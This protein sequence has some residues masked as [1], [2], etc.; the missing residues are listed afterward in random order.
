M[1][2]IYTVEYYSAM[3]RKDIGWSIAIW[4][5]LESVIQCEASQKKE[6]KGC[7]SMHM[8]EIY[9]NGIDELICRVGIETQM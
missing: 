4:I 8:F 2:Y 7:L 1:W 5:D 6:N 3:K 9:K